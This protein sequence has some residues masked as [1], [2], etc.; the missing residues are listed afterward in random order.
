MSEE[1]RHLSHGSSS[2]ESLPQ[3]F[4]AVTLV[5]KF[6]KERITLEDLPAATTIGQVKELLEAETRVL[7]KR[8]KLVGLQAQEGGAR[9]VHDGLPLSQLRDK[10]KSCGGLTQHH[11]I[12]MGTPEEEIFV[13]PSER[14]DLPEIVDD[15]DLDL[16]PNDV[17]NTANLHRFTASTQVHL[18]TPPREGKP[19]LVLDLDHTLLDFSSKSLRNGLLSPQSMKRPCMDDF[20]VKCYQYYDLV[21]WSQT[22]W[23]WLE[24]KLTELGMLTHPGYKFC[25]VLDKTSMFQI[26]SHLKGKEVQHHVKP[27]QIIWTKFPRWNSHNTVH[28]D[29]LSRNFALNRGSGLKIQPYHRKKNRRDFDLV[30]LMSYLEQVARSGRSFDD[31]DFDTWMEVAS[32]KKAL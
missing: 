31:I 24:T 2:L 16:D 25:F 18:I 4:E 14:D 10:G 9:G 29:D 17:L 3:R 23:R 22:S 19:L 21:V 26:T 30:A 32:G 6:G 20:L 7:P 12:L 11:F 8:Q 1:S 15:F 5:A 27:L 13:D 28:V